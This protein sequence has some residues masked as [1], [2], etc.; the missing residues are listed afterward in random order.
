ML[1]FGLRRIELR[2]EP[3]DM[4]ATVAAVLTRLR[5]SLQEA[6]AE[7]ILPISW[8]VALGYPAWVEEVWMNYISNALKYGGHPPRMELGATI[9]GERVRFWIQ[10]NGP[11]LMAEE[12][13][14]LFQPFERLGTQRATGHGLGLSIV[15]RI[16][17][18]MGGEVG[19]ECS[20][21][22]GDGCVFSFTLPLAPAA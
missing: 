15:R 13:S 16:V 5:P 14:R 17:E 4:A 12:Q 20:G 3:L 7:V 11:G 1:L 2:M 9:E 10:D 8:P 6:V 19:V 21:I 18:K 22:P